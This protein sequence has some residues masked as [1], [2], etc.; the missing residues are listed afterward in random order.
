VITLDM[1]AY[2][3]ST[4][5]LDEA[6]DVHDLQ[7]CRHGTLW[8]VKIYEPEK[9]VIWD[10]HSR[11]HGARVDGEHA[12]GDAQHKLTLHSNEPT[13]PDILVIY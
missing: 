13:V 10:I 8:L 2:C 1:H 7:E 3:M 12:A 6:S 9:A 5:A 11:L 4:R